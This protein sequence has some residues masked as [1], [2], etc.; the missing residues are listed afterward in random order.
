MGTPQSA[1]LTEPL[2]GES[3]STLERFRSARAA[4]G[5][6]VLP[7]RA[8][9]IGQVGG[10]LLL[11][12]VPLVLGQFPV[13]LIT[14]ILV[15]GLFA[16]SLDLLVGITGL[17]S[18]GHAAYYGIGAYGAALVAVHVTA[19]G[20]LQLLVGIAVGALSAALTGWVAVRTRAV[21]FL[22]LTVAITEIVASLALSWRSLTHGT[23]GF[24]T[25]A[26]EL[27]PGLSLSLAGYLY[28]YVLV[29]VVLAY[30]VVRLVV[31][32]PFGR[33]LTGIRENETRMR[34]VGYPTARYKYAAFCFAGAIAG[35]AGALNLAQNQ[36]VSPDDVSF[37]VAAIVFITVIVGGSGSLFGG[38]LGATVVILVRDEL[39]SFLPGRTDLVL[40]LIFVLVVYLLPQG[41]A[42]GLRQLFRRAAARFVARQRPPMPQGG[43]R[44]A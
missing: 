35:L 28:W 37:E 39:S 4:A 41:L 15:F 31:A 10:L 30:A 24:S 27:V 38:F 23:N 22:M 34:A 25:P 17:P 26:P 18:L 44:G 3:E 2:S 1:G 13:I 32:S 40:G 8:R 12:A 7:P 33:A 11:A 21:Y 5:A 9:R 43:N 42:G 6:P 14:E 19:N 36:F 20:P 29:V 16:V